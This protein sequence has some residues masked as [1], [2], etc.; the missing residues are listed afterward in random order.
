MRGLQHPDEAGHADAQARVYGVLERHRRAVSQE[1]IGLCRR[2]CRFAAVESF[3]GAGFGVP[4]NEKGAAAETGR[5]RLDQAKHEFGRN[6]RVDGRSALPQNFASRF[7]RLG[8]RSDDHVTL[9][10]DERFTLNA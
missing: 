7:C 3:H 8:L 5:L 10:N 9:R 2:R 4:Q 1:A 6:C